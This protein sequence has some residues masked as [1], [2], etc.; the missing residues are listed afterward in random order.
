MNTKLKLFINLF[1]LLAVVV[2]ATACGAIEVGIEPAAQL[3]SEIPVEIPTTQPTNQPTD[4]PTTEPAPEPV[5]NAV[6]AALSYLRQTLNDAAPPENL[7][8]TATYTGESDRVGAGKYQF[9]A[10]NWLITIDYPIV[11][12]V[13]TIYSII[14]TDSGSGAVWQGQVDAAGQVLG[15]A[16]EDGS[17]TA[18]AWY[19]SV[20]STDAGAQYD[21]YLALWP[22]SLGQIGLAGATPDVESQIVSL[23]D[24]EMPGKYAHF[25]GTLHCDV[26]DVG[27]CQLLV[28]RL[29]PDGP[30]DFFDPDLVDGWEGTLTSIVRDEPGSGGDDVFTLTGDWPIEYG[31]GSL[32]ASIQAQ[33]DALRDSGTP[34]RIWGQLTA[35]VPDAG[36][37][38]IAVNRI[39]AAGAVTEG[40]QRYDNAAYDF[41]FRYP[42]TWTL[43]ESE[44]L[45]TLNQGTTSLLIGFRHPDEAVDIQGTGMPAGELVDSYQ[46]LFLDGRL[47]RQLLVQDNLVKEVLYNNGA[48]IMQ[49]DLVLAIRLSNLASSAIAGIDEALQNEADQ[50][51]GT[52]GRSEGANPGNS[53]ALTY[54][55]DAYGFSFTYPAH[56]TLSEEPHFIEL[57][58]GDVKF[59]IGYRRSDENVILGPGGVGAGELELAGVVNFAGEEVERVAL[60]YEGKVKAVYYGYPG[61]YLPAGEL[62][63]F[64]NLTDLS[65]DDYSDVELA[66]NLQTEVDA[67]VTS[68]SLVN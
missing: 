57:S 3:T 7:D 22:E 33:L 32:D 29:R 52:F 48:E 20:H 42:A 41:F 39:E 24:K 15:V 65:R 43:A 2:L 40:W 53:T 6:D 67:I 45:V 37:V 18:V 58:Q 62:E 19:G 34:F 30:G 56:W 63:F 13:D 31:I 59:I 46:I 68:F 55:N 27:N 14:V 64:L 23:R 60:V 21:D 10:D 50:I 44:H 49:N 38:N 17:V 8:W 28:E 36:G 1:W 54:A 9:S 61:Q 4:Q 26:P 66:T 25:W 51:L 12:P 11:N 35:G 47:P 5:Q 16:E